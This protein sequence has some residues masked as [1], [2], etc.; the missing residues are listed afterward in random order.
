MTGKLSNESS[1]AFFVNNCSQDDI[2]DVIE[3]QKSNIIDT[4]STSTYLY[5]GDATGTA[6]TATAVPNITQI[7]SGLERF[8]YFV[9][10]TKILL[11]FSSYYFCFKSMNEGE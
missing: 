7:S 8:F 10:Q 9:G 4:Y 6:G 1:Y 2:E 11:G 3:L 5:R